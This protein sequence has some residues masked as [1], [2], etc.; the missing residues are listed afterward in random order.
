[1]N[2]IKESKA[3]IEIL[4]GTYK[5][6][7]AK[8]RIYLQFNPE[9]YSLDSTNNYE[10]KKLIGLKD[11]I[12]QFKG[13]SQSDLQLDILFD[14]TDTG[15]DVRDTIKPLSLIS[16][17]DP[18]LHAPPPCLFVWAGSVFKGVVTQ[19]NKKF[20]FFYHDG[21]PAR[22]KI[23]LILKPYKTPQ[24]IKSEHKKHSSDI[25]KKRVLTHADNLW[26]MAYKEYGDASFWRLIATKNKIDNPLIIENGRD[27]LLPPKE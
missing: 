8:K 17:I 11:E 24:E 15:E 3:Y 19:L 2:T 23:R 5:N 7:K 27:L 26:L 10:S 18:E 25:T 4:E 16:D 9:A 21:T 22:V 1:M 6:N 12:T 13:G 20:T 14:S